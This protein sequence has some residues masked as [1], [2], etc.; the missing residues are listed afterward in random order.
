MGC[1]GPRYFAS[2]NDPNRITWYVGEEHVR[3]WEARD[4]PWPAA[5]MDA[6]LRLVTRATSLRASPPPVL[7]GRS[8]LTPSATRPAPRFG[9]GVPRLEEGG[10]PSIGEASLGPERQGAKNTI[11][12]HTSSPPSPLRSPSRETSQSRSPNRTEAMTRPGASTARPPQE[13]HQLPSPGQHEPRSF[14]NPCPCA[15]P[16]LAAQVQKSHGARKGTSATAARALP[17]RVSPAKTRCALPARAGN[18]RRRRATARQV[19]YR[20]ELRQAGEIINPG[21]VY[22]NAPNCPPQAKGKLQGRISTPE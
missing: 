19:H 2:A 15:P 21:T 14:L 22:E 8:H 16:S 13:H 20:G 9:R 1:D 6:S 4:R 3:D 7:E 10:E 12:A 5:T 11:H 18:G 17:D